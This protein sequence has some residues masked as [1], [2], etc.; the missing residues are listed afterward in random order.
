MANCYSSKL[1]ITPDGRKALIGTIKS[2]VVLNDLLTNQVIMNL[3]H[4]NRPITAVNMTPDCRRIIAGAMNGTV[5]F[6]D[7]KNGVRYYQ[8]ENAEMEISAVC[9]SADGRIAATGSKN[10]VIYVWDFKNGTIINSINNNCIS[11]KTDSIYSLNITAD[12][13][14]L[15]SSSGIQQ[16]ILAIYNIKVL[17][18]QDY[19]QEHSNYTKVVKVSCNNLLGVSQPGDVPNLT[20]WDIHSGHIIKVLEGD[21]ENSSPFA[22]S[23][24]SRRI[25]SGSS[26]GF[27]S[28][29][30]IEAEQ[31]IHTEN[32]HNEK[33]DIL[34]LTPDGIHAISASANKNLILWNLITGDISRKIPIHE[35][36]YDIT[37]S[38]D[39]R[40]AI[41]G[42]YNSNIIIWDIELGKGLFALRGHNHWATVFH[43]NPDGR[44]V[45]SGSVDENLILWQLKTGKLLH[46]FEG[47]SGI[48]YDICLTPDG[49]RAVSAA[50]DGHVIIWDIMTGIPQ[51]DKK[52]HIDTIRGIKVTPDGSSV[53]V[54]F[55]DNTFEIFEINCGQK[56]AHFADIRI[57]TCIYPYAYGIFCGTMNGEAIVIK[58]TKDI[59]C[60]GPG[61]LTAKHIWNFTSKKY[62]CLTA[63]CPFCATDFKPEHTVVNTIKAIFRSSGLEIDDSPCLSLTKE[64]WEEP[65]LLS[66]CPKCKEALKFNPFLVDPEGISL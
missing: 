51:L 57:L 44:C 64:C 33:A 45:L 37:L 18:Q 24:D 21:I 15:V 62:S 9:L 56:I 63:S 29:R 2:D 23:L 14:F 34:E 25:V 20:L 41:T 49:R 42:I 26:Q 54:M 6:W 7:K 19:L 43:M 5:L 30:D 16:N 58:A 4:S 39:G 66:S 47:H 53:L 60:P 17:A 65:R 3:F 35:E 36:L 32:G 11:T 55:Q 27:L 1:C 10:G 38:Q 59:Y 40:Y 61:I 22:I 13:Y 52:Y 8:L 12:G 28:I 31:S 50:Q 46:T 48:I